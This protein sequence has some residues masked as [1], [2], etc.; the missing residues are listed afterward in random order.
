MRMPRYLDMLFGTKYGSYAVEIVEC[1]KDPAMGMPYFDYIVRDPDG[2]FFDMSVNAKIYGNRIAT[3][4]GETLTVLTEKRGIL[5]EKKRVMVKGGVPAY[6]TFRPFVEDIDGSLSE[7]DG[8]SL[9]V[10]PES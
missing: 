2:N 1:C 6:A 4:V 7:S 5:P 10:Q 3:G 8:T 9:A